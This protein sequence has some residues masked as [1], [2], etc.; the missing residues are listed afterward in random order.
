[1]P[2]DNE[3]LCYAKVIL[4][5]EAY[6]KNDRKTLKGF[7]DEQRPALTNAAIALYE[8][9]NVPLVPCTFDEISFFEEFLQLQSVAISAQNLTEVNISFCLSK[10][11][12]IHAYFPVR[13]YF[14][15][16][17][18]NF[19]LQPP[20]IPQKKRINP[21]LHDGHFHVI[22]RLNQFYGSH[23]I[24][25]RVKSHIRPRENTIALLHVQY[26]KKVCSYKLENQIVAT[27]TTGFL[28]LK[29]FQIAQIKKWHQTLSL[30]DKFYFLMNSYSV[31][32]QILNVI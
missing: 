28:F 13:S 19:F 6:V 3:G 4:Y 23:F 14:F 20:R 32:F 12:Y 9:A 21:S 15:R 7:R 27:I 24:A 17:C 2:S 16:K 29:L 30:C 18:V 26:A 1:M 22:K 31:L 5:A 25:R 8:V 10:Y 11:L